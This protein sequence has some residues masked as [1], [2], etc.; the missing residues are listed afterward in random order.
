MALHIISS[1]HFQA[2]LEESFQFPDRK[3]H[4]LDYKDCNAGKHAQQYMYNCKYVNTMA[5]MSESAGLGM[6]WK[7]ALEKQLF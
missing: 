7:E 1:I 2:N 6:K 5:Y 4:R 3:H